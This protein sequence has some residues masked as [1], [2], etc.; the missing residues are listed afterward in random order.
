[1]GFSWGGLESLCVPFKP[2]RTAKPWTR[3]GSCLRFHIGLEDPDDL[4]A[5][6]TAGFERLKLAS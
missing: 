4:I 2:H 1:M 5:D 3:E 6:I